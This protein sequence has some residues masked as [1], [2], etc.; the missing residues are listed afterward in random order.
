[1][2]SKIYIYTTDKVNVVNHKIVDVQ[3]IDYR[4]QWYFSKDTN[5]RKCFE[6][7]YNFKGG[8]GS[9]EGKT[10]VELNQTDIKNL[11]ISVLSN[12]IPNSPKK[13]FRASE[14]FEKT[15]I[16]KLLFLIGYSTSSLYTYDFLIILFKTI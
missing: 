7:L 14:G 4:V 6:G 11:K 2:A 10:Y 15:N 13:L 9:F 3:H 5:L 8:E 12:T 16:L 1:M